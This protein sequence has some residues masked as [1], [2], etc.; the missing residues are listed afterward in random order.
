MAS[1]VAG[2]RWNATRSCT[3][4]AWR[5][6]SRGQRDLQCGIRWKKFTGTME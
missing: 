4:S 5:R 2:R 6:G 1:C 3:H